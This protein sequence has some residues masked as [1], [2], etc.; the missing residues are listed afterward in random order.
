[1]IDKI[2]RWIFRLVETQAI[3]CIRSSKKFSLVVIESING[4]AYD[5]VV[6]TV[7]PKQIVD[8][9]GDGSMLS[10]RLN[11]TLNC[12]K[13]HR[14]CCCGYNTHVQYLH[15]HTSNVRGSKSSGAYCTKY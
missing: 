4:H 6:V 15:L 8:A 2:T 13:S 7:S 3:S 10:L 14:D 9:I 1:M 5:R 12:R 11:L